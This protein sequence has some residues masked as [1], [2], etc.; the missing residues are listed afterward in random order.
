MGDSDLTMSGAYVPTPNGPGPCL[1]VSYRASGPKGWSGLYWQDPA[2]NWGDVAGH[3]GYDLRGATQLTFRARGEY[4]GEKVHEF[5][6]G[7]IVGQYPDS[8]VASIG[9]IRLSKEWTS[10]SIDLSKKD[11]RHIIGGFGLFMNKFENPGGAVFYVDD[12]FYEGP[13]VAVSSAAVA[14]SMPAAAGKTAVTEAPPTAPALPP[15]GAVK[16]LTVKQV[17]AG[18]RVSFSSQFLFASGKA[19]LGPESKKILDELVT[20]L[21]VYPGNSVLIEGHTDSSGSA[22]YNLQL[23]RLRAESVRDYLIK[24]GGFDPKRFRVEGYGQTRPVADNSTRSG[25]ALNRRVEVTILK[26]GTS[27]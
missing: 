21:N 8:D 15:P 17:E 16:N 2:N 7:G 4:G 19:K 13:Q 11:L 3:A 18:L 27:Q 23:S 12:I 26:Q 25:R 22:E 24:Q 20:L 14:V 5:R 1:R 6:V 9:P 10:Y